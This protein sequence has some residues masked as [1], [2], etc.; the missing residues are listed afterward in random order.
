MSWS[1]LRILRDDRDRDNLRKQTSDTLPLDATSP[2]MENAYSTK[3]S[4][5][6]Q[7]RRNLLG[8]LAKDLDYLESL[9]KSVKLSDYEN[10]TY[11]SIKTGDSRKN[12]LMKKSYGVGVRREA[13][14]AILFLKRRQDF[15]S[16]LKPMYC[17]NP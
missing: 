5:E 2:V 12:L 8:K 9:I 4:P 11:S 1:E 6:K 17:N 15:W 10:S 13:Q 16:Q 14:D 3:R 7:H